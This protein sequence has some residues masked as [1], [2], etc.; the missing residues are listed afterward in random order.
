V[1]AVF[2]SAMMRCATEIVKVGV[3]RI[4]ASAADGAS[5][6]AKSGF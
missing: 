6:T 1:L 3:G 2:A 4:E 5:K